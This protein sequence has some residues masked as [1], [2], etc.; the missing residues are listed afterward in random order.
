MIEGNQNASAGEPCPLPYII[1]KVGIHYP[2]FTHQ[3]TICAFNYAYQTSVVAMHN[4][5]AEV[6][7]FANAF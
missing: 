1:M 4:Y 2:V 7:R 6:T 3:A 5:Y